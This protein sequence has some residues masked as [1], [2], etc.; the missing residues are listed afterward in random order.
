MKSLDK[1][2][3]FAQAESWALLTAPA[4]GLIGYLIMD[5]M[6]GDWYLLPAFVALA[7]HAARTIYRWVKK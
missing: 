6:E 3:K 7:I 5:E 2:F 4:A 1:I